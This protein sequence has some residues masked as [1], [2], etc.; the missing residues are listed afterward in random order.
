M[1]LLLS[2]SLL[3]RQD[4]KDQKKSPVDSLK[5]HT[6]LPAD[7]TKNTPKVNTQNSSNQIPLDTA[8]T[9]QPIPVPVNPQ[10]PEPAPVNKEEPKIIYYQTVKGDRD[11]DYDRDNYYRQKKQGSQK[12]IKTLAGSMSHSGGFGAISFKS[13]EIRDEAIVFAGL[14]GGWIVNRTLGIGFEGYGAIPTAKFDDIVPEQVVTLGGYGGMFLE[15]ILFS[16]QVLH[17][18]FPVSGG[19]G[20]F[21]YYEDWEN[22]NNTY[23]DDLIDDDVFWYVEPGVD[24]EL[25]VSRNFRLAGGVS[26]RYTQDLELINTDQN[27][28]ETLSYFLTLKI[29]SF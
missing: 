3:A 4:E 18:T 13:T 22:S 26:K 11:D 23:S 9:P 28:F 1:L 20:W 16:N 21:G 15:L 14:R 10:T 24:L 6:N 19:A 27:A 7:S 2:F 8:K 12:E 17:V 25:N 29:G 5:Q